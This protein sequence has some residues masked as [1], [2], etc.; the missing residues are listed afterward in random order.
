M[1][2]AM[3]PD[4]SIQRLIVLRDA[5]APHALERAGPGAIGP[6]SRRRDPVS[7]LHLE[8]EDVT[9]AERAEFA[10]DPA[11]LA[12]SPTMPT[13]LIEPRAAEPSPAEVDST[14]GVVE[15][16]AAGSRYSGDGVTVAVLDTGIDC[17]HPAFDGLRVVA[18]DFTGGDP[19]DRN[20][21]GTHCAGTVL[22]RDVAGLRI[23]VARGVQRLLAGKV[24]ADDGGGSSEMLFDGLL[25]AAAENVQVISLSLGFDFPG[26]VTHRATA[27]WPVD[28][29]TSIALEAYTA[30]LRMLDTIVELVR[31]R[32]A[33]VVAAAGNESRRDVRPEYAITT[34]LPAAAEGVLS[35]AAAGRRQ[36]ELE[37]G[38]FS[39]AHPR[40]SAPGVDVIS[41]KAGGGLTALTGTSMAAP[42]V[43]GV[44]A[45]WWQAV[46]AEGLPATA[47]TVMAK[48][49]GTARPERF[50]S[51]LGAAE[52][53]AGVVTAP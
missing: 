15:V 36:E 24:L 16:G 47:E 23:G 45:L 35:V 25:W 33:V 11:V 38:F 32:E 39:N 29:A 22:G 13:R 8:V 27:G 19:D 42:H 7:R 30:T 21:H 37:I 44:A 41:A 9:Q 4:P 6:Y 17:A 43:A 51:G 1:T 49:L 50:V 40:L 2:S 3:P 10:A 26:M 12:T 46:R 31:R 53:G 20:G 5:A 18:Q 52:R 28:L 48:L 34:S 14:W